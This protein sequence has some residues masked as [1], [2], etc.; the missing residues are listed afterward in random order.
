MIFK[1][2]EVIRNEYYSFSPDWWGLGCILYEMI[3]GKSPFRQRKEKVKREEIDR[4]VKDTQ[5]T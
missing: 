3:E 1:A 2:P 4:R 5:E